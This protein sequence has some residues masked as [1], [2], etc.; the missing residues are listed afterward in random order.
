MGLFRK[1]NAAQAN[2]SGKIK[3]Q[4]ETSSVDR[5]NHTDGHNIVKGRIKFNNSVYNGEFYVDES[6]IKQLHG[7]GTLTYNN[8]DVYKG[9][10]KDGKENGHGS[11]VCDKYTYDG[12]W[13][14]GNENGYGVENY[15]GL[16]IYEGNWADGDECGHGIMKYTDGDIYDGEWANGYEN[17]H[18]IMKYI[19]GDIYDGE[20]ADGYEN[21]HGVMKYL[22]GTVYDGEWQNGKEHGFGI[23]TYANGETFRVQ[24]ADGK[25]V[26]RE[27][28][29]SRETPLQEKKEFKRI[30]YKNSDTYEG[31]TLNGKRH[32]IGTY[33][34]A[35]GDT[36]EGEWK[37]DKRN[38]HGK[39]TSYKTDPINGSICFNWSYD[40]N[41]VDS[42]M[43]GHGI[44]IKEW[45][46]QNKV[47]EGDWVNGKWHGRFVWYFTDS[48]G[49]RYI[50]FYE[51]NNLIEGNIP[52]S[53]DILTVDDIRN[54]KGN[55][56]DA[57][58]KLHHIDISKIPSWDSIKSGEYGEKVKKE[59]EETEARRQYIRET[60]RRLRNPDKNA[61]P[62]E[63]NIETACMT[64]APFMTEAENMFLKREEE[65]ALEIIEEMLDIN[66]VPD[67]KWYYNSGIKYFSQ[68][69]SGALYSLANQI[70]FDT[71]DCDRF[72]VPAANIACYIW[73]KYGDYSLFGGVIFLWTEAGKDQYGNFLWLKRM[74]D[75]GDYT[76]ISK[77]NETDEYNFG[78]DL[79]RYTMGSDCELF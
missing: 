77:Y 33:T 40:G 32:G 51:N 11:F 53:D 39:Y 64:L 63:R 65:K 52:Y 42:V 28:V 67:D 45:G 48:R 57:S 35:N 38:G 59:K 61:S 19:D 8:G 16:G 25:L 50:N 29:D 23:Y 68:F 69:L 72:I 2:E 46:V 76:V 10:W 43:H 36:Y 60:V 58:E 18:G 73:K 20:W 78:H 27:A 56:S 5:E 44:Y 26:S 31:E 79:D 41:W 12:E 75:N 13:K 22:D 9:E 17:G 4:T 34:W 15:F 74:R 55:S 70:D 14:N 1:R 71:P 47:Y 7:Y 54:V 49:G 62:Y 24:F 66:I 37:N 6:G 30:E 21:G 3:N